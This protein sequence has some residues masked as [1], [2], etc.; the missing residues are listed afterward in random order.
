MLH[1]KVT[2]RIFSPIVSIQYLIYNAPCSSHFFG[3][4]LEVVEFMSLVAL[5]LPLPQMEPKCNN[6]SVQF[7]L[8]AGI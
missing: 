4:A 6:C 5:D 7:Q 2:G 3:Q 1:Y 8:F